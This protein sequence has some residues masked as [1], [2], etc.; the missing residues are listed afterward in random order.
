[1]QEL[2]EISEKGMDIFPNQ[3]KLFYFNGIAHSELE[4]YRDAMASLNQASIMAGKNEA[5]KIDIYNRM[6][7]PLVQQGKIEKAQ[8]RV[9]KSL[10]LD[11]ENFRT[12]SAQAYIYAAQK[13]TAK[14]ESTYQDALAKGGEN[15]PEVLENYGDFLAQ[16]GDT[17][18][19]N[20]YWL[21]AKKAGG[22]STRL[23]NKISNK[24]L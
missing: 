24:G 2:A 15:N 5:L 22:K 7:K 23:Q 13:D 1:M 14:A 3:V 6:V 20:S 12:L 19:A 21:K 8:D 11:Q 16:K 17:E 4:N 9:S 10:A 18:E